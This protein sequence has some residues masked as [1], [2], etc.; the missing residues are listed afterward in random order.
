MYERVN[1]GSEAPI[2]FTL[3]SSAGDAV[4]TAGHSIH[5]IS[6]VDL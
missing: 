4:K 5:D 2:P 1:C 6:A 3:S